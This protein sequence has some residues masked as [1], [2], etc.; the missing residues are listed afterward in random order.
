MIVLFVDNLFFYSGGQLVSC[1]ASLAALRLYVFCDI[2]MMMYYR[3]IN[4]MMMMMHITYWRTDFGNV[5]AFGDSRE[6]HGKANNQPAEH[7]QSIR[8]TCTPSWAHI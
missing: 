2:V 1:K 7:L 3:R 6:R 4:M 8:H 5:D